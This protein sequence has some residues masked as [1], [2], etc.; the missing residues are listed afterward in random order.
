M[1]FGLDKR[2]VLLSLVVERV[3]A[4]R[5]LSWSDKDGFLGLSDSLRFGDDFGEDPDELQE[6]VSLFL[7]RFC[8]IGAVKKIGLLLSDC[9]IVR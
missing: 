4:E 1:D 6:M 5:G 2:W 7:V 3:V 9:G 8:L